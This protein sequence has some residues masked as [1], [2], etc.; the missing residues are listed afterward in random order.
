GSAVSP[1]AQAPVEIA[2]LGTPN[3]HNVE[4]DFGVH[5]VMLA[6]RNLAKS[7][8]TLPGRKTLV[9][10]TTGF[11]LNSERQSELTAVSDACNQAMVAVY[12]IDVRGLVARLETGRLHSV[13]SSVP[14]NQPVRQSTPRLVLAAWQ[15][16]GPGGGGGGKPGGGGGGPVGGGGCRPGG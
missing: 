9:M 1:N 16:P 7:L 12:P 15:R 4:A 6:L 10:L 5:T 2:S 13:A 14:A 3:L 11:P 8:S